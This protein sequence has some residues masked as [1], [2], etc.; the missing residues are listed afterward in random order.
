MVS[1]P[2]YV[3]LFPIAINQQILCTHL[4]TQ[5]SSMAPRLLTP[6]ILLL[7]LFNNTRV[8]NNSYGIIKGTVY[9]NDQKAAASVTVVIKEA[10]RS[11]LTDDNGNFQINR[12]PVG[13]YQLEI[14]LWL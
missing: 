8:Q 6:A 3:K 7:L 2:Y 4:C 9:T 14:S 13:N 10:K 1:F 12:I 5:N 11:A